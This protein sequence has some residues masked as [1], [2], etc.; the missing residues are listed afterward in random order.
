MLKNLSKILVGKTM[1]KMGMHNSAM[2]NILKDF[3]LE[4]SAKIMI[5]AIVASHAA[6][7]QVN[8]M[9]K[10][11]INKSADVKNFS[12]FCFD[13]I[14]VASINGNAITRKI[15]K[16]FGFSKTDTTL[17]LIKVEKL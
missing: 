10:T 3:L 7:D 6:L 11:N 5:A 16:I 1:G 13:T 15:A 9:Q 8:M 2:P 14:L 17:V 12:F 4:I